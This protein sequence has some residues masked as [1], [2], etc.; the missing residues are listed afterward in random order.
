MQTLTLNL[1][2]MYGDHHVIEVRRILLDMPGVQEVYA[3]SCFQIVEVT[4]DPTQLSADAI[5]ARLGEA[6]YLQALYTPVEVPAAFDSTNVK[7]STF[8]RHTTAYE[9]TKQVIGFAQR[10]PWYGRPLWPCP[11]MGAIRSAIMD[12]GE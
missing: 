1:P 11:G 10:V 7:G 8:F 4:Y 12:E 5:S 2:A 3:S 9:Q 6:G